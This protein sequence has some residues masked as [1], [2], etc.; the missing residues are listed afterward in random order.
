MRTPEHVAGTSCRHTVQFVKSIQR[1]TTPAAA[2]SAV[3]TYKHPLIFSPI[4]FSE[5]IVTDFP[6]IIALLGAGRWAQKNGR[7]A[8]AA[9]A[10][11]S[12]RV[13]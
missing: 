11:T 7:T 2:A 10:T 4:D 8:D 5:V 12:R 13:I 9:P 3:V 1:P 6:L